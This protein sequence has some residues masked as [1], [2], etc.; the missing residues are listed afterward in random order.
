MNRVTTIDDVPLR[1]SRIHPQQVLLV[2]LNNFARYPTI[3]IGYL[4]SILRGAGFAVRVFSPLAIGVRGVVREARPRAFSLMTA[5]LNHRVAVSRRRWLRRM[6]ESLASRRRSQLSAE[7]ARVRVEFERRLQAE[8]PG[9]VLVSTYLMYHDLCAALCA[10]AR[11]AGVPVLVGGPYFA[12]M[13]V[14]REWIGIDG[15]TALAAGELEPHVASIVELLMSGADVTRHA[16]IFVRRDGQPRGC[17]APP[18]EDLDAVPFPDY[19][20]FPW[21]RY[22]NRIVPIVTGRGCSWGACRFCSDVTS[23]AGRSF[24][25]RSA[26]NV[27]AEIEYQASRHGAKQFVLTDLKLN[28]NL[29]MWRALAQGMQ[30]AAPGATWIAA[31]HVGSEAGGGNGLTPDELAAVAASGCVRLTTGLE[32][33][34]QRVAELMRKGTLTTRTSAFLHAASAAGISCRCTMVLGYPGER[35]ADVEASARFLREHA[36]VIDRVLLNRFA[37]MAGTAFHAAL[38]RDAAQF[39]GLEQLEFDRRQAAIGHHSRDAEASDH[40]RAVNRLFEAVHAIN[41]R[42]L[43]GRAREF[44]GVI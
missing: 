13:D 28:G 19:S 24:R 26:R 4:A 8:R 37:I 18:L 2:D 32:T 22:P 12:Q 10:A 15:L 41:A 16:G 23:T 6:R 7:Q 31:V 14:V 21:E 30:A 38:E 39:P 9:V 1:G 3:P 42:E 44:E 33:G 17:F 11:R 40:R 34:S 36:A 35:A 29:V 5:K 27:L 43:P 20:D 25:S